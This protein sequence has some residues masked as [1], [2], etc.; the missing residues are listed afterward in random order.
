MCYL[1]LHVYLKAWR[2]CACLLLSDFVLQANWFMQFFLSFFFLPTEIQSHH[3][4]SL[5]HRGMSIAGS[6]VA[7]AWVTAMSSI[8]QSWRS[9]GPTAEQHHIDTH[10]WQNSEVIILTKTAQ[11][12]FRRLCRTWKRSQQG[13]RKKTHNGVIY[14]SLTKPILL[15]ICVFQMPNQGDGSESCHNWVTSNQSMCIFFF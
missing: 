8:Y 4:A 3:L 6:G 1:I 11:G 7:A 15:C 5:A 10:N 2:V 13:W 12:G 9:S 14:S